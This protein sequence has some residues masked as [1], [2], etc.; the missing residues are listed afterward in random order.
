ML[1]RDSRFFRY[2]KIDFTS[3]YGSEYY[4]P[5]SLLRVYGLTQI[6]A[7][8]WEEWQS[9]WQREHEARG[10]KLL[11][12]EASFMEASVEILPKETLTTPAVQKDRSSSISAEFTT[13]TGVSHSVNASTIIPSSSITQNSPQQTPHVES[14]SSESE[15]PTPTINELDERVGSIMDQVNITF[16]SAVKAEVALQVSTS[17]IQHFTRVTRTLEAVSTESIVAS[18]SDSAPHSQET[19]TG[20]GAVR[21]SKASVA[22]EKSTQVPSSEE[23]STE[24]S[25]PEASSSQSRPVKVWPG[26]DSIPQ[27]NSTV[28]NAQSQSTTVQTTVVTIST[29]TRPS[30]S[31]M[32]GSGSPGSESIYR[33][34]M[35]RLT[36]LESNSSLGV[37]YMEEQTKYVREALKR[38][39]KD[40]G[41]LETLV[42]IR[43]LS[44][45]C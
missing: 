13:V 12:S 32:P 23:S 33:T 36:V 29:Q 14:P 28:P 6:E 8:K 31:S 1:P 7:Y 41:R 3:H 26:P 25:L 39:E 34:I 11:P 24:T 2:I 27:Q 21:P 38:L 30:A 42:S 44:T 40:V 37:R 22:A 5:I 45:T 19:T 18:P 10:L 16:T 17:D 43:P 15:R 9:A 4:C 20:E 35:N